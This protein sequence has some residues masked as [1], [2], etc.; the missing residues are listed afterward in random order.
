MGKAVRWKSSTC[1]AIPPTPPTVFSYEYGGSPGVAGLGPVNR[2]VI[3][4]VP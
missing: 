4:E 2:V 1:W 3:N